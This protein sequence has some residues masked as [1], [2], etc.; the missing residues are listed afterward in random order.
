MHNVFK[1]S[2]FI[3]LIQLIVVRIAIKLIFIQMC[4]HRFRRCFLVWIIIICF[5][6]I[7]VTVVAATSVNSIC[8]SDCYSSVNLFTVLQTVSVSTMC[9]CCECSTFIYT[10]LFPS[11]ISYL[12]TS[13]WPWQALPTSVLL[14]FSLSWLSSFV[15]KQ[16]LYRPKCHFHFWDWQKIHLF[17]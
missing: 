12:L 1:N 11:F 8:S 17:L 3:G 6:C 5:S 2:S 13:P 14:A 16:T 4:W 10:S 7:I 15:F 9:N